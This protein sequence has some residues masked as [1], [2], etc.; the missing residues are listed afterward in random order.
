M[1]AAA[2]SA[3]VSSAADL[4]LLCVF[5]RNG[6][7]QAVVRISFQYE[8]NLDTSMTLAFIVAVRTW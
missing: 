4:S 3:A 6:R 8:L 1:R 7:N 5:W 2:I